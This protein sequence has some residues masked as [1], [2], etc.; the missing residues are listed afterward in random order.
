MC[1]SF[2]K[3]KLRVLPSQLMQISHLHKWVISTLFVCVINTQ[4]FCI[5]H[6][7]TYCQIFFSFHYHVTWQCYNVT[8][9]SKLQCIDFIHLRTC[10]HEEFSICS[11]F[12][13]SLKFF[14]KPLL[15]LMILN[16]ITFSWNLKGFAQVELSK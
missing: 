8:L 3:L 15:N 7:N 14:I 6:W 16:D 12:I 2:L 9:H 13:K 11:F 10:L 5:N 1:L 4:I